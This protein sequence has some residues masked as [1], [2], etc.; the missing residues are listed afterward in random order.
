MHRHIS[1]LKKTAVIGRVRTIFGRRFLAV[2]LAGVMVLGGGLVVFV[3]GSSAGVSAQTLTPDDPRN[4]LSES[5]CREGGYFLEAVSDR[6]VE[7]C[8]VLVRVRNAFVSHSDSRLGTGGVA[9][10]HP[11]LTWGAPGNFIDC[12]AS[13]CSAWAG[14]RVE[15]SGGGSEMSITRLDFDDG[16]PQVRLGGQIPEDLCDLGRLTYLK[17]DGN[18]FTG[19][20]PRCLGSLLLNLRTL[21]FVGNRLSGSIPDEIG[22]LPHLRWFAAEGNALTGVLPAGFNRAYYISLPGQSLSGNLPADLGRADGYTVYLDLSNNNFDG[23]IPLSWTTRF[24][25]VNVFDLS[26]N[27]LRGAPSGN[28]INDWLNAIELVDTLDIRSPFFSLESN[29][30]CYSSP[31]ALAGGQPRPFDTGGSFTGD[32]ND[33]GLTLRRP[34]PYRTRFANFRLSSQSCLSGQQYSNLMIP[35]IS[36]LQRD[37][38]VAGDD[39][40][41]EASWTLPSANGE[42]ITPTNYRVTFTWNPETERANNGCLPLTNIPVRMILN[43]ALGSVRL[44]GDTLSVTLT[45]ARSTFTPSSLNLVIPFTDPNNLELCREVMMRYSSEVVALY[46]VKQDDLINIFEGDFIVYGGGGELVRTGSN[47]DTGNNQDNVRRD[48]RAYN[49]TSVGASKDASQIAQDLGVP[50]DDSMYSW[51]AP[52]QAWDV[53][54]VSAESGTLPI[55]TAVMYRSGVFNEADLGA[56]G[57]GRA[58]ESIVLTL[59]QGWNLL[60]PVLKDVDG[61]GEADDDDDRSQPDSLFDSSLTDCAILAGVLA[62]VTYDLEVDAFSIYLP[63]HGDLSVPGYGELEDIDRYDSLFVFFRSELPVPITWDT[64]S[65]SYTPNV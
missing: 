49:V 30:I 62:L 55:G 6:L 60:A 39:L 7:E 8:K 61:D 28:W 48:W 25:K 24:T 4:P 40:A 52:S 58:D 23:E 34:A 13:S 50:A 41:V 57:V 15:S 12:A 63:C 27:N 5:E 32:Y 36:N 44:V 59:H 19:E 17:F 22:E 56:A 42:T 16:N 2:V 47:Q 46:E 65:E 10:P 37:I 64:D 14:V 29:Q 53:H 11:I 38:V 18:S 9:E 43:A 21:S 33:G 20:I 26:N 35:P 54:P 31:P 1:D 3:A 45:S 51:N